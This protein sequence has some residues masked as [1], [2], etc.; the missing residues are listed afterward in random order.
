MPKIIKDF[1]KYLTLL[2]MV[3]VLSIGNDS[4]NPVRLSTQKKQKDLSEITSWEGLIIS[5]MAT[6][7]YL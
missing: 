7:I 5:C 1:K 3:R 4:K 6:I 2:K